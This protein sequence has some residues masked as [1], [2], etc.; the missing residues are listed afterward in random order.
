MRYDLNNF[1]KESLPRVLWSV[2]L[3]FYLTIHLSFILKKNAHMYGHKITV[4]L[5]E[6]V[7]NRYCFFGKALIN[8]R[9]WDYL[10]V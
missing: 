10:I 5:F 8:I 9:Y 6:E 2:I 7:R 3:I 1:L 4:S